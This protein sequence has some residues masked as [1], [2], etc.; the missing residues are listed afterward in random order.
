MRIGLVELRIVLARF[1]VEV[2]EIPEDVH[3]GRDGSAGPV[4]VVSQFHRDD[5][6]RFGKLDTA[7]IAHDVKGKRPSAADA[8][9]GRAG[10]EVFQPKVIRVSSGGVRQ[11]LERLV[12]AK[13]MML[14]DLCWRRGSSYAKPT[15]L[16]PNW[17]NGH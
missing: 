11:R 7:R 13:S 10:Q 16:L 9:N 5:L 15:R 6:L 14:V 8:V 3:E 17:M 2:D 4:E 12:A 1:A